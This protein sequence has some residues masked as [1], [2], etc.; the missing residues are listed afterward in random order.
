MNDRILRALHREPVDRTP[1]WFMRQAGRCLPRYREIRAR[2]E[3]QEIVRNPELTARVT[4]LP[5]EYFPVDAAVLFMDLSTPFPAAGLEVEFVE[6]VG[7]VPDRTIEAPEDVEALRPFEPRE[8]L[9]HVLDAIRILRGRLDVPVV[10]FV[11]APFTLCSYLMAGSR[12]RRFQALKAFL[13]SEPEAWERLASFWAEHLAEF[14]IAQHEAGAG[15]VQIFDSWAG[16]LAPED[17]EAKV[18]PHSARLLRRLKEAGVPTIHFATGNPRLYRLVARAGGDAVSVDWRIP[19][20]E[21]W[22]AIGDRAIQGNLDPA[23]LLAGR[24]TALAKARAVLRR[25]GGRPG[26]IFNLGHGILPETD[27]DVLRAVAE[28]VHGESA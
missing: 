15:L 20:D 8:A 19:L 18:L 26:H 16:E 23:A 24:A 28:T 21:A 2:H 5:L 4:V 22:D 1:V 25:A 6:G 12:S 11:G 14:A 13:W 7:P 3:F 17:Y 9:S 10:G 27:P